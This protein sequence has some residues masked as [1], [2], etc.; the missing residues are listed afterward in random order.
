MEARVSG[1]K[2]IDSRYCRRFLSRIRIYVLPPGEF[3]PPTKTEDLIRAG[4]LYFSVTYGEIH[5]NKLEKKLS[6]YRT[7]FSTFY[8]ISHFNFWSPRLVWLTAIFLRGCAAPFLSGR[9][10]AATRAFTCAIVKRESSRL[11]FPYKFSQLWGWLAS[12]NGADF[13]EARGRIYPPVSSRRDVL[14]GKKSAQREESSAR[15]CRFL[16]GDDSRGYIR[17]ANLPEH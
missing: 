5:S 13:G 15:T 11:S 12:R 1:A 16:L 2:R 9:F 10:Y 6:C 17:E 14:T 7:F 3:F 8:Y 4:D